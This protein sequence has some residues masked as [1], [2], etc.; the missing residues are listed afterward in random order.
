M[1][2][3]SNFYAICLLKFIVHEMNSEIVVRTQNKQ[4]PEA[5]T[6]NWANQT[7]RYGKQDDSV[8]SAPTAI[9]GSVGSSEGGHFPSQVASNQD[10]VKVDDCG[11]G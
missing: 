7:I 9:R 3:I 6:Q 10:R 8:S 5:P 4:E 2:C 1:Y 11:G